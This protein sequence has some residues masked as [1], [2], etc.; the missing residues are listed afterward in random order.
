MT[1]NIDIVIM[2]I[3]SDLSI[4]CLLRIS[5]PSTI[6]DGYHWAQSDSES[7]ETFRVSYSDG[8]KN[9]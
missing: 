8:Y 5:Q 1:Y 3:S 6:G 2:I 7:Q 4:L 9:I